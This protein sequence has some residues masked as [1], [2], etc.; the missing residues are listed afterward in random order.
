VCCNAGTRDPLGGVGWSAVVPRIRQLSHDLDIF[1]RKKE[2]EKRLS[3]EIRGSWGVPR[4]DAGNVPCSAERVCDW[5]CAYAVERSWPLVL[6]LRSPL[7]WWVI[8]RIFSE[9]KT[10]REEEEIET[11]LS[12]G[13]GQIGGGWGDPGQ[14]V[15]WGGGQRLST[16]S[17]WYPCPSHLHGDI[18]L[19]WAWDTNKINCR[20][21]TCL[22]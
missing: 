22:I 15:A 2:S 3:L 12:K 17:G 4:W 7:W 6:F 5:R 14:V 10:T 11:L 19:W 21:K 1:F 16:G 18:H 9:D 13:R 20:P 8:W